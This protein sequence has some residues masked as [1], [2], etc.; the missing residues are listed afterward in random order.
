M[1]R[2]RATPPYRILVD[3]ET[4]HELPQATQVLSEAGCRVSYVVPMREIREL[5]PGQ[6]GFPVSEA[7]ALIVGGIRV[8][9]EVLDVA[10]NA[11]V[12]SI[13]RSGHDNIDVAAATERGVLVTNARGCNAEQCADFTW[14]LIIALVRQILR[15]DRAIRE[16]RWNSDTRVTDDVVGS[17]L[18]VVGLGLIG[19]GV[20]RRAMGFNMRVIATVRTKDEEFRERYGIEFVPL[21]RL[22]SESDIVS[23]HVPVTPQTE[24]MIN[25]R[26]LRL[27]KRT[28]YLVNTSRGA[29]IDEAALLR[30][31]R[32]KWIAGAALDAYAQEPLHK[33]PFFELD[34]VILTPH[35]SGLTMKSMVGAAVRTARN[36]LEVL[37][38]NITPDVVNP[39]AVGKG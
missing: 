8:D 6:T 20:A 3:S 7:D 33:S 19:R 4:F 26:A 24:K 11:K 36:A 9:G 22:L 12:V 14:G 29:L 38:G 28:A 27:M 25:E 31:L 35:Q 30:A 23:L 21:D 34:N 1:A 10:R 39:E 2:G 5:V 15:G 16:G 17:T 37:N 18:G 13:H 32:E